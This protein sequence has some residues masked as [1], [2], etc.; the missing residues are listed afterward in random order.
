[1]NEHEKRGGMSGSDLELSIVIP[2]LNETATLAQAIGLAREAIA[3]SGLRGEIVVADNG[4]DDGSQALAEGLGAR[5]VPV[6]RRGYGFA[7]MEGC[8]RARGAYLIMGD[9]D[10]TYDFREAVAFLE[11]LKAGADLVMGT[12]LRGTIHPGAMPF[13]HRYVG[14]PVLSRLIRGFFRVPISDCNCGLRAFTKAAFD[15]LQLVSGGMEFASEMIIKA[16]LYHLKVTERPCSLL[17]DRRGKPPHLRRWRDGWRHLRFILLFA[18]HVI[19]E[20][21]GWTMLVIGLLITIPV[22]VGPFTVAGR[23]VDYHYLFYSIPLVLAGYQAL[24]FERV[25]A[26]YVQFAGYLPAN[27]RRR[28]VNEFNLEA[29]LIG[30]GALLV[31]GALLLGGIVVQW[32]LAGFGAL[33]QMRLGAAGMLLLIVGVQTVMNAMVISMMDIKVDRRG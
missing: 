20:L 19:F 16:G 24:W 12:R 11:D 29:W 33:G 7:L 10:A 26:Y 28:R 4:S 2:C 27:V 30:G 25:E 31:A 18:P 1:V 5:V 21:P 17:P 14:T 23:L 3:R 6:P 13:L 15:R 8:R 9:A 32:A 22:L